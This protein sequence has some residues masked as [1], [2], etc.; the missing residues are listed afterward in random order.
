M[1]EANSSYYSD[2][3]IPPLDNAVID[4]QRTNMQELFL[5]LSIHR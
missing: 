4:A 3:A 2:L 5:F 1:G